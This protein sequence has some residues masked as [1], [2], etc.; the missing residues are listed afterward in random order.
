MSTKKIFLIIGIIVL[1][2]IAIGGLLLYLLI[3][4]FPS[5]YDTWESKWGIP[6]S[7]AKEI[8]TVFYSAGIQG[9]GERYQILIYDDKQENFIL[10]KSIETINTDNIENLKSKI[11]S[12][13]F[14]L[15]E[16]S[17]TLFNENQPIYSEGDL[18]YIKNDKDDYCIII[19]NVEKKRIYVMEKLI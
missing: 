2:L 9:D 15:P 10:R 14:A 7:E 5:L 12:Y 1:T 19:V 4:K 13:Y 16:E 3:S 18:Y 8:E 17:K 6:I 11:S